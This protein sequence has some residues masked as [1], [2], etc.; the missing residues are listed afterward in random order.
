MPL[1][2]INVWQDD[3]VPTP[4]ELNAEF[5]NIVNKFSANITAGDIS[6][7]ILSVDSTVVNASSYSTIKEAV[8]AATN[9]GK[10]LMIPP[11]TY[12]S[13]TQP[14]EIPGTMKV[15]GAGAELVTIIPAS[16]YAHNSFFR[17]TGADVTVSGINFVCGNLSS[18][19]VLHNVIEINTS[20][21]TSI[22][23]EKCTFDYQQV[24]AGLYRMISIITG[25]AWEDLVRIQECEFGVS[26][27]AAGNRTTEAV[28][29][30]TSYRTLIERCYF[31]GYSYHIHASN[32]RSG[33]IQDCQF[34]RGL[35]TALAMDIEG[36]VTIESNYFYSSALFASTGLGRIIALRSLAD[37]TSTLRNNHFMYSGSFTNDPDHAIYLFGNIAAYDNFCRIASP[38]FD[39]AFIKYE[40]QGAT[41]RTYVTRN[42]VQDGETYSGDVF[43]T[44][45]YGKTYDDTGLF[46]M[47]DVW[48]WLHWTGTTNYLRFKQGS[49]P[50]TATDDHARIAL[51]GST[52]L[53]A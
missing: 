46:R 40:G 27:A 13:D 2:R 42:A 43:W 9:A 50:N 17:I 28:Y 32:M 53:T 18:G 6:D 35:D 10:N 24:N 39:T 12:N 36:N 52:D 5:N 45:Q 37:G 16:G 25:S 34:R 51:T 19:T 3:D 41:Y 20:A 23:I 33:R 31:E 49:V 48:I 11:G 22:V 4:A 47:G 14:I 8:I 29:I 15:I 1:N 21:S 38:G 26:V 44:R 7:D 30:E